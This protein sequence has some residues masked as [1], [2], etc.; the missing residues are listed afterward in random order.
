MFT[1]YAIDNSIN[2]QSTHNT[3]RAYSIITGL[4]VEN[5]VVSIERPPP[6]FDLLENR[7]TRERTITA[8]SITAIGIRNME[9]VSSV[10]EFTGRR[11]VSRI[12]RQLSEK[13][14]YKVRRPN[15]SNSIRR[16]RNRRFGYV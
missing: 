11:F 5:I 3:T 1:R 16:S 15:V 6:V 2:I 10:N 8:R 13:P 4:R 12:V 7:A 14:L 9:I